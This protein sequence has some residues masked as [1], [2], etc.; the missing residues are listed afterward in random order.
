M[1]TI[2]MIGG[3][4]W[5]STVEY[6]RIMNET[7]GERL[8]GHHSA[9]ILMCSVDFDPLVRLSHEEKWDEIT[10]ILIEEAKVLEKGGADFFIICANTLHKVADA[11]AGSVNIP[12]LHIAEVTA[13]QIRKKGTGKVAVLGTNFLMEDKLYPDALSGFGIASMIPEKSDRE[14][15]HNIIY[16]ELVHGR[17]REDSRRGLL[18]I[19]DSLRKKGAEGII[20]GCTELPLI[21]KQEDVAIPLFNTTRIH[22]E[23]AAV[24][25]ME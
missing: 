21:I 15:I 23:A 12:L 19:I 3:V 2:G 16:K 18:A 8:G 1:K 5:Q 17:I 25:S 22:A 4:S 6:Y 7:V 20:L 13:E 11:V 9:R 10:A 14:H 24:M